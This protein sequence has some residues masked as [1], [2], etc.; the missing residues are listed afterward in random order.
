MSA[1]D[2]A[3]DA[4]LRRA[5][6]ERAAGDDFDILGHVL[7]AVESTPQRR[8]LG[9]WF[10][11][12]NRFAPLALATTGLVVAFLIV[13]A[14]VTRQAPDVGPSP[15]PGP[16]NEAT[17][18]PDATASPEVPLGGGLILVTEP[19]EPRTGCDA[20]GSRAP[21]DL[22]LLDAGT[23]ERTL[24]GTVAEDCSAGWL[25]LQWAS[26]R[27]HLL[28]TDEWGQETLTLDTPTA[29][30]R[31]L[32]FICCDFPTDVW[33]G[34]GSAFDG[35]VLS[36]AGDRVSAIHTSV[37]QI[38]GQD[39]LGVPI[40][41]GIV[42]VNSDGSESPTLRLPEGSA[43]RGWAKWSPDSSELVVAG[44]NPCNHAMEDGQ[45]AT[46][47][48]HEHIYVVPV[49]GSPV[50]ELLDDTTGWLWTPA[51]SPDG[52]T[53][54][55]IRRECPLDE[56]PPQCSVMPS[57]SL[58][59][60]GVDDG[61]QRTLV[62]SDQLGDGFADLGLPFWS[63]DSGRIA[64]TASSADLDTPHVFVIDVDG[65]N[66]AD[67][68][69]GSLLQWSPDGEWLLVDR[70]DEDEELSDI[71]IMRADGSDARSIGQF[72]LFIAG[73]AW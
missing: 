12:T 40:S 21:F 44:C 72:L 14:L 34:G 45:P 37:L 63:P 31:D 7:R 23:G 46:G 41:D 69:A 52:S 33:E 11:P 66:L 24:L 59:L 20:L 58:L 28:M 65:T 49:D 60:V 16:T 42:V 29:A 67:L 39:D 43:I 50:R 32:T 51:W 25:T 13:L 38:P 4:V 56:A 3:T 36:P 22:S 73:V 18:A 6:R 8:S 30:G 1:R 15:A 48:N 54:V 61:A 57:S 47:E 53:F 68:G 27:Q 64:F 55:T 19:H 71:W 5:L 62:T 9:G 10:R 26:D 35:W 17:A 70:P 2:Q